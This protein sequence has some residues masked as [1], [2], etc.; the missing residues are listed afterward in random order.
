MKAL[1]AG[2]TTLDILYYTDDYPLEDSKLYVNEQ[3]IHP[4]G[5]AANAAFTFSALGAEAYLWTCLG[6]EKPFTDLILTRLTDANIN[7]RDLAI[8][9]F[10][11]VPA[12]SVLINDKN[13][14]RTVLNRPKL[15]SGGH[16]SGRH[17]LRDLE[18][19][20]LMVDGF[21]PEI[22][23]P[24]ALEAN[25]KGIPVVMDSGSWKPGLELLLE[26]ADYL[27]VGDAFRPPGISDINDS[28]NYL[29][30]FKIAGI[31][32]TNGSAPLMAYSEAGS[33][34]ISP[35]DINCID[36]LGAGDVLHGAFCYY[37]TLGHNFHDSLEQSINIASI[38]C[39][40]RG[41]RSWI[42]EI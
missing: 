15:I 41:T 36:S 32:L 5:M 37:L 42:N 10:P 1:F 27:I 11:G 13:G 16:L 28:L 24:L 30:Q 14:S 12:A 26:T 31:A 39:Q 6:K 8:D 38:S 25:E 22:A 4:G 17:H 2:I 29:K 23:L 18:I 35:P 40:Y 33:F 19:D 21:Y 9:N 34:S 7:V 3:L 20:V